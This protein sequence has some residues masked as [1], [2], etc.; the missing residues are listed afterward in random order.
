MA[1]RAERRQRHT[2]Q[3]AADKG[4][5][6]RWPAPATGG[7]TCA[8]G[9]DGHREG[10]QGAAAAEGTASG[11]AAAVNG[12]RRP[13]RRR[14]AAGSGTVAS[15][16]HGWRKLCLRGGGS[17]E[18]GSESGRGGRHSFWGRGGRCGSGRGCAGSAPV[19]RH[20]RVVVVVCVHV[21][22]ARGCVGPKILCKG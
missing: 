2:G 22:V 15:G 19:D 8:F 3:Q 13:P 16:D 6:R 9:A 14:R 7:E 5:R 12:R 1:P 10:S 4:R 11:T 21:L 17:P 20:C 18:K